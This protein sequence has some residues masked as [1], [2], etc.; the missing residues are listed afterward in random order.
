MTDIVRLKCVKD[1]RKLRVRIISPGYNPE[2]NCQFPRAIRVEGR[3]YTVPRTAITFAESAQR[4]FFYRVKKNDI[5][6]AAESA[7]TEPVGDIKIFNGGEDQGECI[8]CMD[9]EKDV[10]FAPCGHYCCCRSC[11]TSVK[12]GNST[13]PLCRTMIQ[14]IVGRDQLQ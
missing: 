3:E 7:T 12:G 11:A 1:G 2:A 9:T 14:Q 10:V 5:T 6:I 8:I 4:K 13:C